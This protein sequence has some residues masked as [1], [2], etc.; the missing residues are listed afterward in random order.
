LKKPIVLLGCDFSDRFKKLLSDDYHVLGPFADRL[1]DDYARRL[2]DVCALITKGG[3]SQNQ[4]IIDAAPE[5]GL[6]A[7]FGTGFEGIDLT[8]ASER[9]LVVT[10]SPGANAS[11]VADF[12]MGLVLASTRQIVA[13]DRFVRDGKWTSNAI[14]SMP[15][16]AGVKG[17]K[18][19]IFG[20]GAVGR[21]VAKRAV[22]FEMDIG[23]I[24]RAPKK[25]YSYRYFPDLEQL[26]DWADIL[27]VAARADS[28]NRHI[29]GSDIISRIGAR[30]H[31]INIARGS[32]IDSIALAEALER[33]VIAGAALDVFENEPHLPQ[34]LLDAPGLIL[35]P[36]IAYATVE[37]R[38]VQ[39]DMVLSNLKAFFAG[40][41]VPNPVPGA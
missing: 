3:V 28:G 25:A 10:H 20:L 30:G 12:A 24:S 8:G 7:F 29:I 4:H 16:V 41:A 33:N 38:E 18:L 11:S 27:L 2:K 1:A 13:A 15:A 40:D 22:A 19:G 9:N 5:L 26:A 39:E 14:V 23:Y 35:S 37:A 21:Q 17:A 36:H 34:Q 31:I 6:V 32:L